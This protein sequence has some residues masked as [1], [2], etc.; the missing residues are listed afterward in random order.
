MAFLWGAATAAYQIEGAWDEDGKGPS[1]WDTFSHEKGNVKNNE[2]G[3][4]ACDHYHRYKEDVALMKELGLRCYR[5]SISWPRI[6]PEGKGRINERGIKFYSNLIDL[7]LANGIEPVITLYHW[8]LPQ[9][10]QDIGG[11]E[12]E[13]IANLFADY[14]SALFHR[15]GNRVK[16]W[17]TLNEPFCIS[18]LGHG[19]GVHAP[20]IKDIKRA[21]RVSHNLNIAHARAVHAFRKE[22]IEKGKIGITLNLTPAHPYSEEYKETARFL[23]GISNRWF[24]DPSLKGRYPEDILAFFKEHYGFEANSIDQFMKPDFLGINYYSRAIVREKKKDPILLLTK[25]EKLEGREY[26]DMGWEVYEQ[27]LYEILK[28]VDR[29]YDHPEIYVTE[30]GAAYKDD[31]IKEGMVMDDDRINYLKKHFHEA[32]RALMDGV[33]LK[34]YC[35]W[36]LMDNFEWAE[37]YSKRF[38]IVH[39]NYETLER[40]KKKS[41]LWYRDF[42]AQ[43]SL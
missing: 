2:N 19:L 28:R 4:I 40:K 10:L 25:K 15:F 29:E 42:I 43:S 22:N 14:A 9:P 3:D 1:I 16:I 5:F 23:D 26:T 8:D 17:I 18:Y 13:A 30:N 11:W 7:L 32:E 12:N 6:F 39:V 20:G 41:A 33:R 35:V 34:G 27:G 31:I 21:I 38:G 37:G 24:L 36:S